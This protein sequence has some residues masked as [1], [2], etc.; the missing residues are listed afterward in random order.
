MDYSTI[1]SKINK[2]TYATNLKSHDMKRP[3]EAIVLHVMYDVELVH[4]NC[5]TFNP[6]GR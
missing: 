1:L 2:G 6:K 3:M 4:K 5:S